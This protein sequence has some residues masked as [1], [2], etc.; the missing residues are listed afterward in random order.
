M[1]DITESKEST[2]DKEA[3]PG[4]NVPCEKLLSLQKKAPST[5]PSVRLSTRCTQVHDDV[6]MMSE[7]ARLT[8]K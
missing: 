5:Q 8:M 7:M 4:G 2:S 1:N 3:G 6:T